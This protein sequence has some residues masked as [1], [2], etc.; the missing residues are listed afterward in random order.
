MRRACLRIGP[1][2]P[3]LAL[4]RAHEI[5]GPARHVLAALAAGALAQG[6]TLWIRAGRDA[7]GLDP[8]GLAAFMDPGRLLVAHAPHGVDALWTAEEALRSGAVALVTL[9]PREPPGLTPVRRLQ[10]AA[11]A[12]AARGPARPL[13]LILTPQGGSAAAVETRWR[14]DP[15]PGWALGGAPGGG[16]ARWRFA[17]TRDKAGPPALWEMAAP[18]RRDAAPRLQRAAA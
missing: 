11:E 17:L 12:G 18:D 10:L 13:C 1:D 2:G 4:G 5:C 14:A 9:E 8:Q 16:P 6:V 7:G 3:A 15:A